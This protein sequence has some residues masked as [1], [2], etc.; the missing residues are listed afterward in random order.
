M[1]KQANAQTWELPPLSK[2]E[3]GRLL[4]GPFGTQ[5]HRL[6]TECITFFV[7]DQRLPDGPPTNIRNGTCFFIDTG[8]RLLVVTAAH[9]VKGY[10]HA[11]EC[12]PTTRCKVGNFRI[13]PLE[14]LVGMG[15]RVDIATMGVTSEELGQIVAGRSAFGHQNHP[16]RII[17]Q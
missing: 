6:A 10:Q 12:E 2:D 15:E 3:A 16:R 1:N 7:F 17:E 11:K 8:R 5:L 4:K 13:D 14:R 9:V